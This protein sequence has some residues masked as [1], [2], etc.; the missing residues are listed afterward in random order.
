MRVPPVTLPPVRGSAEHAVQPT[1]VRIRRVEER[2]PAVRGEELEIGCLLHAGREDGR[3]RARLA[4]L[5]DEEPAAAEVDPEVCVV[6]A[7][8][9]YRRDERAAGFHVAADRV[10]V[11]E[12]RVGHGLAAPGAGSRPDGRTLTARPA[13]VRAGDG[14]V[15]LFPGPRAHIV[16]AEPCASHVGAEAERVA[17]AVGPDL[18]T[19]LGAARRPP[20]RLAAHA[21]VRVPPGNTSESCDAEDLPVRQAQVRWVGH[22]LRRRRRRRSRTACR[23]LRPA[24][25]RHCGCRPTRACCRAGSARSSGSTVDPLTWNRDTRFFVPPDRCRSACSCCSCAV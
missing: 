6:E 3:W 16:D 7:R 19:H 14:V 4:R 5:R 11:P 25:L 15:D 23:R 21:A 18:P 17:E 8:P 22:G 10:V 1:A 2:R 9:T 12:H 13:V 20:R 24:R